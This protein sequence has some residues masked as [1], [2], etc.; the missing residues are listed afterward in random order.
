[1]APSR[2]TYLGYL[3]RKN[4]QRRPRKAKGYA[5]YNPVLPNA[6]PCTVL[7]IDTASKSGW[8]IRR[9]GRLIASGELDT[10][11]AEA[12]RWVFN[13]ALRAAAEGETALVVIL[14]EP[15][16]GTRKVLMALGAARD[17]WL[18]AARE[19]GIAKRRI[20]SVMPNKWR[21]PLFGRTRARR[22]QIRALEMAAALAETGLAYVGPDEAAAIGI[23][24]W[25]AHAAEVA[26]IVSK[27][28]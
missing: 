4:S 11:E 2:Q 5:T 15:Y 3:E 13:R 14:E 12:I 9:Q 22:D 18:L 17:R 21:A 27:R 28:R 10:L 6:S 24:R 1:M 8:A 26:R 25:G 7:G 20:L 19:L 16:G 23:S